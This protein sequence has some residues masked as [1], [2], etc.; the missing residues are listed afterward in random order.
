MVET[1][2]V[3][4]KRRQKYFYFQNSLP[5]SADVESS[6]NKNQFVCSTST[7]AFSLYVLTVISMLDYLL[8][9]H[10]DD[11]QHIACKSRK[12]TMLKH[13]LWGGR[14]RAP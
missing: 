12:Q 4:F 10:G 5:Y 6:P 2:L 13:K 11:E 14:R 7:G 8:L 3:H 9:S 1:K